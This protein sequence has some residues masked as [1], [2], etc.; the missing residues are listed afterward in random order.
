MNAAESGESN[1]E[2]DD[3]HSD[4]S[5]PLLYTVSRGRVDERIEVTPL[6]ASKSEPTPGEAGWDL[7]FGSGG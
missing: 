7:F 1:D 3:L 5:V 2:P 4:L 6:R